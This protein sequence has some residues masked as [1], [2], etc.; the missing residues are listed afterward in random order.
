VMGWDDWTL[1]RLAVEASLPLA[2][3]GLALSQ[4]ERDGW[5]ART[6]G[7]WHRCAPGGV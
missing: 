4:L 3:V 1:S 5:V 7:R 2:A 6:A